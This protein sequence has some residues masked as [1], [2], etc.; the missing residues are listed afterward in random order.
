MPVGISLSSRA[1]SSGLRHRFGALALEAACLRLARVLGWGRCLAGF[2]I[3]PRV[4]FNQDPFDQSIAFTI[5]SLPV[6]P[7]LFP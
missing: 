4:N 7:M 6:K 2:T 3:R 1:N 5:V